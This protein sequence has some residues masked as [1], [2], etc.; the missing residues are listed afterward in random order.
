MDLIIY[1]ALCQLNDKNEGFR[2][3]KK[4]TTQLQ[5]GYLEMSE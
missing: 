3:V 5:R 2:L 1:P 4:Y